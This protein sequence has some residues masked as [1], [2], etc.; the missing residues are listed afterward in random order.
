[1]DFGKF[2]DTFGAA[3]AGLV[4]GF[5][6]ANEPRHVVAYLEALH[7]DLYHELSDLVPDPESPLYQKWKRR[8]IELDT[9][10]DYDTHDLNSIMEHA[11]FILE[12]WNK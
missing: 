12:N 8:V 3:T 4:V 10:H 2:V 9:T 5:N 11:K 1:M 7:V 6:L